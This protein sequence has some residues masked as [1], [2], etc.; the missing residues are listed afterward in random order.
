MDNH[1][2]NGAKLLSSAFCFDVL[3][4]TQNNR[5]SQF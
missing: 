5:R 4:E 2:Q 3:D 1:K